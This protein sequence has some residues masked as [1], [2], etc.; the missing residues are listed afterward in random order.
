MSLAYWVRSILSVISHIYPVEVKTQNKTPSW[1][2]YIG[3]LEN[4]NVRGYPQIWILSREIHLRYP[5][6]WILSQK[7]WDILTCEFF[8]NVWGILTYE[9]FRDVHLH[10]RAPSLLTPKQRY[11]LISTQKHDRNPQ[12]QL[13]PMRIELISE[14]HYN[15]A[16]SHK[17]IWD[18]CSNR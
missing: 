7:V 2:R 1:T 11:R 4:R 14:D 12:K 6:I 17:L 3:R 8:C 16:C 18:L 13:P 15:W 5:H 9:F 10:A